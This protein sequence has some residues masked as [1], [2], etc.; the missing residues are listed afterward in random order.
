MPRSGGTQYRRKV[1]GGWVA[2]FGHYKRRKECVSDVGEFKDR[3]PPQA[4]EQSRPDQDLANRRNKH[5]NRHTCANSLLYC[6]M[7]AASTATSAGAKA[8]AATKS[9]AGLLISRKRKQLQ[10]SYVQQR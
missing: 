1:F 3:R 8:G 4:M 2:L 9:K 7:R 10:N 5:V 6:S